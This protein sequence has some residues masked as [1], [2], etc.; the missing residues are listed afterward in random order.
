MPTALL[1]LRWHA[2][3]LPK[4]GNSE[5]EYEDAFA[6]SAERA[7]FAVADGASESSFAGEWARLLAQ[8]FVAGA[9]RPWDDVAWIE[10][11]R[12]RWKT[13]VGRKPLPWYAEMK[14][15]QG[16]FATFLGLALRRPDL[17]RAVAVGDCCMVQVRAG[18]LVTSF[19]LASSEEFGNRPALIGSRGGRA[20]PQQKAGRWLPGDLFLLM[21]DALA[22]WCLREHERGQQ[23]WSLFRPLLEQDEP[24]ACFASL[25]AEMREHYE[26]KNDDVTLLLAES[27]PTAA[28]RNSSSQGE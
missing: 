6:A 21:T 4:R 28:S 9:R 1:P 5:Q 14:R 2:F 8:G 11:L 25:V 13:E 15:E 16:A 10:S 23:P 20:T 17:W 26:L 19:P 24:A 18:E 27:P 12:E 3:H 22:Q 7:R